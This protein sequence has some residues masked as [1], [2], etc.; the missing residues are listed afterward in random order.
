MTILIGQIVGCLLVAAGIG[1]IIGWLLRRLSIDQL[2]QHIYDV[3]T[4]LH[5]KEQALHSAQGELTAKASTIQTNESNLAASE[6]LRSDRRTRNSPQAPIGSVP[7]KKNSIQPRNAWHHW[8]PNSRPRCSGITRA[9]QRSPP[10][11]QEARQAQR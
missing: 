10:D 7:F 4:T 2:N 5:I 9:T 3:T 6:A 11:V 8:N 1:G